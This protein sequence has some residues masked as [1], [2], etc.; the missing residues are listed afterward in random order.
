[1]LVLLD[2]AHAGQ[3]QLQVLVH[4]G[5]GVREPVGLGFDAVHEDD[6]H[7]R[8]S[9]IVQL[10]GGNAHHVPPGEFLLVEGNPLFLEDIQSH[11]PSS[12][13]RYLKKNS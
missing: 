1:L 5:G 12:L 3:G 11:E 10:A 9:V 7:P 4:A 6:P 2:P 8:K 13:C